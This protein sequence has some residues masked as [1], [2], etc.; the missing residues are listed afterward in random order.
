MWCSG[1]ISAE[2]IRSI[3]IGE[4]LPTDKTS[5]TYEAQSPDKST[6]GRPLTPTSGSLEVGLPEERLRTAAGVVAE[7][8]FKDHDLTVGM[9]VLVHAKVYSFAHRHFFSDL[10]RFAL[11]RLTQIFVLA[12]CKRNSL[13]PYLADAIRYIYDTIPRREPEDPSRTLLSQYIALN[14]TDLTGEELD[15]L[16]DDGGE[17]MIDVTNKLATRIAT[18]G[19]SARLMEDQVGDLTTQVRQWQ[20]RCKDKEDEI[21]GARKEIR[22]WENWNR[23]LSWNARRK[24]SPSPHEPEAIDNW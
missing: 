3:C 5:A 9:S 4:S 21:R 16:A 20:T 13:F 12:P 11:Q 1:V 19:H 24:L 17:F 8:E 23:G 6:L 15:A 2:H 10:A 18:S 14:Y 22:E 7:K